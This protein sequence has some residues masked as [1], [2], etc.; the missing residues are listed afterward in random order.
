VLGAGG[1]GVAAELSQPMIL[2]DGTQYRCYFNSGGDSDPNTPRYAT[3]TDGIAW[4]LGGSGTFITNPGAITQ[5]GNRHFWREGSSW[6]GLQE[7]REGGRWRIFY[8]TSSDGYSWTIGNGSAALSTL[9]LSGSH[10][11][12]GPTMLDPGRSAGRTTCGSTRAR[13]RT[14]DLYHSTSTDRITWTTPTLVL[15]HSGSATRSTRSPTRRCSS[16]GRRPTCSMRAST[17]RP[18][19]A[20]SC[21]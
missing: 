5:W 7:A 19:P 16:S 20:S 1:S 13:A 2:W 15:T 3:S 4:T 8:V 11:T 14:S 21:C 10:N 6:Y 17:T 12:G 9:E 18:R